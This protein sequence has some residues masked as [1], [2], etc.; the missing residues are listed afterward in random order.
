[1]INIKQGVTE[2]LVDYLKRFKQLQDILK[3]YL[4]DKILDIFIENSVKYR[5]ETDLAKQ[6]EMKDSAWEYWISYLF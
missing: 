2:N 6:Q 3:S 1:M 4:G 5:N